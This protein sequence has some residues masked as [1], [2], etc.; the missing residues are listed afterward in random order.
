MAS[1]R[2][3]LTPHIAVTP[4]QPLNPSE[5]APV[6]HHNFDWSNVRRAFFTGPRDFAVDANGTK[7]RFR[8]SL[9]GWRLR[10]IELPPDM[11]G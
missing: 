8:F 4:K 3:S 2:C 9:V 6:A 1:S 7:L 5:A 10:E 11:H